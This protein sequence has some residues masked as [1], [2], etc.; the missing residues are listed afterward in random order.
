MEVQ[1]QKIYP[2]ET[3]AQK[4][5]SNAE[6]G[7]TNAQ[8]ATTAAAADIVAE[9]ENDSAKARPIVNQLEASAQQSLLMKLLL[10]KQ[11]KLKDNQSLILKIPKQW[12]YL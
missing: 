9:A 8:V 7:D 12:I 5:I 4:V 1:E 11:M 10:K 6:S 3:V 2:L